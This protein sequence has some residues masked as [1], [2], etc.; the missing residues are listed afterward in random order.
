MRW[1]HTAVTHTLSS[2]SYLPV[3][4]DSTPLIKRSSTT[5][6]GTMKSSDRSKLI[7]LLQFLIFWRKKDRD[8]NP[9]SCQVLREATDSPD[10][11]AL[12]TTDLLSDEELENELFRILPLSAGH[13]PSS[14][15]DLASLPQEFMQELEKEEEKQ[16]QQLNQN[17][18]VSKERK[19]SFWKRLW[20][21]VF[22]KKH[23]DPLACQEDSNSTTDMTEGGGEDIYPARSHFSITSLRQSPRIITASDTFNGDEGVEI[24]WPCMFGT[25]EDLA[26]SLQQY[27]DLHDDSDRSSKLNK[28]APV[29]F[30]QLHPSDSK[31]VG[32]AALAVSFD[33]AEE[34]AQLVFQNHSSSS[35]DT[36]VFPLGAGYSHPAAPKA[37]SAGK[38]QHFDWQRSQ[39]PCYDQHGPWDELAQDTP[40]DVLDEASS[41]ELARD[42]GE[43]VLLTDYENNAAWSYDDASFTSLLGASSNIF[44][45]I[46]RPDTY[47]GSS[48]FLFVPP[49]YFTGCFTHGPT[50]LDQAEYTDDE[51]DSVELSPS[52]ISALPP[53]SL[54]E[55]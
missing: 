40:I 44:Q 27:F 42:S 54:I 8:R 3:K 11:T 19:I 26:N 35:D 41:N 36:D 1:P 10:K 50:L 46:C 16:Q 5:L 37:R 31:S 49:S 9:S 4:E 18:F 32:S 45:P 34:C 29:D 23:R 21:I 14:S 30:D 52:E 6:A 12:D 38:R 24:E 51:D 39:S 28:R 17:I 25:S 53:P 22:R 7:Q 15:D 55:L 13:G 47:A 20:R 33:N 43:E 48:E 2:S